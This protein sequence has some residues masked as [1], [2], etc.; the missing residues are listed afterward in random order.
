M[1]ARSGTLGL[2]SRLYPD[3]MQ[4]IRNK[5]LTRFMQGLP[6]NAKIEQAKE[7]LC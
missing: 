5:D 2:R 4:R 1:A 7:R 3:N 6:E